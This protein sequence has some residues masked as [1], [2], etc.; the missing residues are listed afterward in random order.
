MSNGS[1]VWFVGSINRSAR[2]AAKHFWVQ[3]KEGSK[4]AEY[5][6]PKYPN[7]YGAE[8]LYVYQPSSCGVEVEV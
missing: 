4:S 5:K 8:W 2:P 6:N 1:F 7:K 3:Y